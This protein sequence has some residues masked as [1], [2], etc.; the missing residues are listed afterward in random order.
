MIYNLL[1]SL[2]CTVFIPE[3]YFIQQLVKI[4]QRKHLLVGYHKHQLKLIIL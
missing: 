4:Q 1:L 2:L 3:L